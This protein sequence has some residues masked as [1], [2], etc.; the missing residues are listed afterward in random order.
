MEVGG[1][2]INTSRHNILKEQDTTPC[3][4]MCEDVI[5]LM[6]DFNDKV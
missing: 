1:V 5:L 2:G 3:E 4:M 6:E